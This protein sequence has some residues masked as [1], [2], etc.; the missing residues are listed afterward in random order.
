[1]RARLDDGRVFGG[2]ANIGV[3]PTFEGRDVTIECHLF[4]FEGDLYGRSL[5]VAFLDRLRGEQ[6]F[7]GVE[8]LTAQIERD[9]LAA[10][11]IVNRG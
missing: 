9:V 3:K 11:A 1:V 2:A 6:R 4:D 5:R 10:R 8:A 7:A